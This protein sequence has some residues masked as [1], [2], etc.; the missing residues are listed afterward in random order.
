M[1]RTV[2]INLTVQ[3]RGE[4]RVRCDRNTEIPMYC[5]SDLRSD[6]RSGMKCNLTC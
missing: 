6:R 5:I 2:E 3:D 4:E 1:R